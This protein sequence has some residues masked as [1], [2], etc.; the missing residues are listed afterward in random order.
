MP[1]PTQSSAPVDTERLL[2]ELALMNQRLSALTKMVTEL[3][4]QVGNYKP[5]RLAAA[6]RIRPSRAKSAEL[7]QEAKAHE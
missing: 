4:T 1:G 7:K 6:D 2:K 3:K 5:P